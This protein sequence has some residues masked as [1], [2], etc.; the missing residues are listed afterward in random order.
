MYYLG[1]GGNSNTT[2]RFRRY[3]GDY[4]KFESGKVRPD[5]IT[6]YTDAEHLLKPNHWYNITIRCINGHV[7]YIIDGRKIVDYTDVRPYKS[8]WFGFRT[9]EARVRFTGFTSHRL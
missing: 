6:E 2:T 9:T 7:E 4:M 5:I 3:D 1:Y 8:G